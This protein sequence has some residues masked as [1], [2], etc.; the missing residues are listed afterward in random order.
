MTKKQKAAFKKRITNPLFLAAIASVIYQVLAK[1]GQ[2]P[3]LGTY[4]LYVDLITYA[5][6]GGGIYSTFG[7]ET[8]TK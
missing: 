2:A 3:D 1:Y 6:L 5:L 8:N 7:H 4:Q